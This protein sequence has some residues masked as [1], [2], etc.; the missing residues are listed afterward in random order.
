MIPRQLEPEVMDTREE[1]VD[2]DAMDHSE[3]NQQF[4]ASLL[5]L[6]I[7]CQ[8]QQTIAG[9]TQPI[10]ILDLGT[11]TALIPIE[12]CRHI[13]QLQII[14][15]DLAAEMLKIAQ[16]N[17]QRAG[18]AET[19]LLEHADAKQLPCEN[20][21]FDGMICNSLIHHIPEPQ[22]VFAEIKRVLKP[23]GF[24]FLRDLLRPDSLTELDRLVTCYAADA[25]LHQRQMF[26][27][28]LHAALT[29]NEVRELLSSCDWTTTAA[30]ITSD[31]HWTVSLRL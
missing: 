6:I 5:P 27:D 16:Q 31:R 11:G 25:N 4:A 28:S 1:A 30:Q 13:P 21:S 18:L 22:S 26:Q 19:I 8:Q 10:R 14:A 17:I 12:I 9:N 24:L 2:Y 15:T 20:Q 29:L 7:A 23:G 3:V